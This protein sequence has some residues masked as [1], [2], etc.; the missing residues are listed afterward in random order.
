MRN[1]L[2]MALLAVIFGSCDRGGVFEEYK[3]ID[4]SGWHKDS[5]VV[6]TA[7]L[8]DTLSSYNLYLDI[9]NKG[10]Y[11]NSNLWLFVNIKSPD[12]KL[13]TDT[14]EY[15]LADHAGKWTGSGIGD[16]FDNQFA[17][18]QNVYFPVSGD[19]KFLI[20]HGMRA[21]HLTGIQDVGIRIEKS[22]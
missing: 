5:A 19:Y 4:H 21:T 10:N 17:Y 2:L 18:K 9:R 11:P 15:T 22:N 16:L 20:R 12:G 1:F 13:L 8:T 7:N 6:F 3:T 14:I